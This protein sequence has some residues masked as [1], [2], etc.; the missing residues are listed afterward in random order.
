METCIDKLPDNPAL[1][2]T[3]APPPKALSKF[4]LVLYPGVTELGDTG[5]YVVLVEKFRTWREQME[6]NYK[7]MEQIFQ[8]Y[9]E[10]EIYN[11]V[12]AEWTFWPRDCP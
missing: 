4:Y 11:D 9:L 6:E 10:K 1:L 5:E 2:Y 12:F 7:A 3:I 8:G